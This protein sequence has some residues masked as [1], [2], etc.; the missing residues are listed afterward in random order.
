MRIKIGRCVL[1]NELIYVKTTR[2]YCSICKK[3][4]N[5]IKVM[6]YR[7]NKDPNIK[8]GVGSGGNQ[9]GSKNPY[10]KG[11]YSQYK[12]KYRKYK[13]KRYCEVCGSKKHLL[14]HHKD[15]NRKNGEIKNLIELCRSCHAKEHQLHL[16]F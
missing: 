5:V 3:K 7:S 12:E 10:Y 11:G 4:A 8:V 16:N 9:K 15:G 2:K 1:C 6:R 14:I 13:P